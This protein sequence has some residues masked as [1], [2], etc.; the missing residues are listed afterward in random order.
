MTLLAEALKGHEAD[1]VEIRLEERRATGI[2]YRGR[3]LEDV[4]EP[5]SSGGNVRALMKGGWGFVSFNDP[6]DLREKVKLAVRQARLVG[7]DS[8]HF[9]PVAPAEDSLPG[10]RRRKTPPWWPGREDALVRQYNDAILGVPKVE[11][12]MV[13][14]GDRR[15]KVTFANSEGTYIEQTHSDVS[16]RV[17]AMARDG[18]DVQQAGLS[19]GSRGDLAR[20]K[21]MQRE[22]EEIARRAV[23]LISA[24]KAKSGEYTVVLDP[25]LAGVFTHEAFGHLSEADFTYEND[26]MKE[27]MVLGRQFGGRHLN[28]VDGAAV[29]GLRGSFKYDDEGV[30]ATKTYLIKEGVLVG[31]LH[32]RETAAKMGEPTTGNARAIDYQHPPIVRMTNTYIEAAESD[33]RGDDQRDQGRDLRQQLV[34][35]HHQHGDVHLLGGRGV[36]HPQ[37]PGGGA[38]APRDALRQRVHHAAEHRRHRQRSGHEPGWRL[39][40]GRAV[41]AARL[42]WQ[43]A[44]Q[45]KKLPGGRSVGPAM[46]QIVRPRL[47]EILSKAKK[48]AEQAE[49]FFSAVD[50]TPV[51]FE[52]NRLKQL[53]TNEGMMVALRLVKNGRIGFSTATTLD[54]IDSLVSRAVEV[55]QFGAVAR[56]ELPERQPFPGVAM[57]DPKVESFDVERMVDLGRELIARVLEHTP[58]L[59][60]DASVGKGVASLVLLNSKGGEAEFQKTF[61]VLGLEGN[62]IKDTDMLFV[63]DG[64]SS[65]QAIT[66]IST[67]GEFGGQAAGVGQEAG[68]QS[69][70]GACRL[71]SPPT[72][73]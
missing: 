18:G 14:Y 19:M 8:S 26:R 1:Y 33:L 32:S 15:R 57:H 13:V 66:D 51:I 24:P 23:E 67:R 60:C 46:E 17:T 49:V 41:A 62:L 20:W 12:S 27:L 7:Q 52:A 50:D 72:E 10:A 48:S 5:T 56:F 39:R 3:E 59:L 9:A 53:Q 40:Q 55:A 21:D 22:V 16:M 64:E 65:C 31:R 36:C 71:Y 43:P 30:P 47:E 11:S 69:P 35:R 61:F 58:D 29:P 37:R 28:I 34:R 2:R 63:G 68:S 73:W 44:H 70:A 42:Q 6:G 54:D 4:S 25:I 38:A 45:D